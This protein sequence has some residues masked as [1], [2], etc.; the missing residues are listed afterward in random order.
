MDNNPIKIKSFEESAF[1][2][3]AK[4]EHV[5]RLSDEDITRK[6]LDCS[7]VVIS[8]LFLRDLVFERLS[9]VTEEFPNVSVS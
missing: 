4:H 8:R 5:G 1:Q 9:L 2:I 6:Y 7:S 3:T